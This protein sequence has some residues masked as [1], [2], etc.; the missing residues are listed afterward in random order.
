MNY[1]PTRKLIYSLIVMIG[2]IIIRHVKSEITNLLWQ[3]CYNCIRKFYKNKIV[4]IDDGSDVEYLTTMKMV[5]TEIIQSEF[6]KRAE[7]LPYYYLL[8]YA[9]FDTAVI[10]HD[11]VF[12][13]S[14]IKF[15]KVNKFM[16]HFITHAH[17]DLRGEQDLIGKFTNSEDILELY[18]KK[19]EWNGCFGVM[20]VITYNIIH[21]INA[22]YNFFTLL[23]TV[24]TRIQ[25]MMLE[26][27]FAVIL[28]K[29]ASLTKDNCSYFGSIETY[30]KWSFDENYTIESYTKEKNEG[31]IKRPIVKL[32]S[33][34]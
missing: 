11:S 30:C 2:F 10:L 19:H 7:L 24:N 8:K 29:E 3:E 6:P 9:W 26:R 27:I 18:N 5:N 13:Q 34:R 32:W 14:P 15:D 23:E 12:I 20:S 25:R 16:W 22:K 4:I 33:G 17:D 1:L 21:D 28:W 31:L